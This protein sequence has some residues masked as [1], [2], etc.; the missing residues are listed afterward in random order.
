MSLKPALVTEGSG[1]LAPC[2]VALWSVYNDRHGGLYPWIGIL[3][4]LFDFMDRSDGRHRRTC[5]WPKNATYE[6]E[7]AS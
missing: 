5:C 6:A 1:E 2:S 3:Q 7:Y 4:A